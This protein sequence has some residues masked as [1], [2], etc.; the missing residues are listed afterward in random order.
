M[1]AITDLL[2]PIN[3]KLNSIDTR[4]NSVEKSQAKL[5]KG[6]A[7]LEQ[8]QTKIELKIENE[9]DRAIKTIG[10]GHLDLNRK[11]IEKISLDSRVE[12]LENKVSALEYVVKKAE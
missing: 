11:L 1:Q 12:T 10:E 8:G 4:L 7:K 2:K 9:I 5:E 6:Q 3:D